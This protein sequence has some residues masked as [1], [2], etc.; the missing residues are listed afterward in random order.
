MLIRTRLLVVVAGLTLVLPLSSALAAGGPVKVSPKRLLFSGAA[1]V[2]FD[3]VTNESTSDVTVDD[4][5]LSGDTNAFSWFPSGIS[6]NP[7]QCSFDRSAI[8]PSAA[9]TECFYDFQFNPPG[10]GKFTATALLPVG[11]HTIK[12]TLIGQT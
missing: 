4:P 5:V 8:G 12:V 10:P 9:F 6:G 1:D 7:D 2:E 3:K 11:D